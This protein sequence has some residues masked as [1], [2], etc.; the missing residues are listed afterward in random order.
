MPRLERVPRRRVAGGHILLRPAKCCTGVEHAAAW[1]GATVIPRVGEPYKH[2]VRRVARIMSGVLVLAGMVTGLVASMLVSA[3][4]M[5][6]T[7]P[8]KFPWG[9]YLQGA[10][11]AIVPLTNMAQSAAVAATKTITT[12]STGQ[13]MVLAACLLYSTLALTEGTAWILQTLDVLNA[14]VG[15]SVMG[16]LEMMLW[17]VRLVFESLVPIFNGVSLVLSD[18]LAHLVTSI[19]ECDAAD[20]QQIIIT[21]L[22]APFNGVGA[23][24]KE[25]SSWLMSGTNNAKPGETFN[26]EES[27]FTLGFNTTPAMIKWVD[28]P[29]VAIASAASCSCVQLAPALASLAGVVSQPAVHLAVMNAVNV[30]I[31]IVQ[32]LMRIGVPSV[33]HGVDAVPVSVYIRRAVFYAIVSIDG[34]IQLVL[35]G[36]FN[37]ASGAGAGRQHPIRLLNIGGPAT[38]VAHGV[39]GVG[40]LAMPAVHLLGVALGNSSMSAAEVMDV[41]PAMA[42]ASAAVHVAAANVAWLQTLVIHQV[43]PDP[44]SNPVV[45]P[46]FPVDFT[47][48]RYLQKPTACHCQMQQQSCNVGTCTFQGTCLCPAGAVHLVP[49]HVHSPCVDRCTASADCGP[50]G[51]GARCRPDGRCACDVGGLRLVYEVGGPSGIGRCTLKPPPANPS[52]NRPV[53]HVP[54]QLDFLYADETGVIDPLCGPG[55]SLVPEVGNALPC[56]VRY[57]GDAVLSVLYAVYETAR[58]GILEGKLFTGIA[59]GRPL[60]VFE[61]Y[62]G[63]PMRRS[64]KSYGTCAQRRDHPETDFTYSPTQCQCQVPHFNADNAALMESGYDPWCRVPTVEQGI[65]AVDHAMYYLGV[66]TVLEMPVESEGLE[67]LAEALVAYGQIMTE[68]TRMG[69][70]AGYIVYQQAFGAVLHAENLLLRPVN[71]QVGMPYDGRYETPAKDADA[72]RALFNDACGTLSAGEAPRQCLDADKVLQAMGGNDKDAT[73]KQ[74]ADVTRLS[75]AALYAHKYEECEKFG[76]SFLTPLC[77]VTNYGEDPLDCMCNPELEIQDGQQTLA[78]LALNRVPPATVVAHALGNETNRLRWHNVYDE[79]GSTRF[80]RAMATYEWLMYRIDSLGMALEALVDAFSMQGGDTGCNIFGQEQYLVSG[81][82][83]L[84][85]FYEIDEKSGNI[86]L[87]SLMQGLT[88]DEQS[89]QLIRDTSPN[90]KPKFSPCT[91]GEAP[92]SNVCPVVAY[93]NVLCGGGAAARTAIQGV[94]IAGRQLCSTALAVLTVNPSAID[95]EFGTIMCQAMREEAVLAGIFSSALSVMVDAAG[96][97]KAARQIRR[98]LARGTFTM[99]DAVLNIWPVLL[100]LLMSG[101]NGMVTAGEGAFDLT[102][103]YS[104]VLMIFDF[105]AAILCQWLEAWRALFAALGVDA[106]FLQGVKDVLGIAVQYINGQLLEFLIVIGRAATHFFTFVFGFNPGFSV[107]IKDLLLVVGVI[108]RFVLNNVFTIIRLFFLTLGSVGHVINNM[109]T[110]TCSAL[111]GF[112]GMIV[113]G[114]NHIPL[115]SL[116]NPFD[117]VPCVRRRLVEGNASAGQVHYGQYWDSWTAR[118]RAGPDAGL[119]LGTGPCALAMHGHEKPHDAVI[120]GCLRNRAFVGRVRRA[121]GVDDLPLDV[122]DGLRPAVFWVSG[123]L[124][125]LLGGGDWAASARKG[126][127]AQSARA[128]YE[129]AGTIAARAAT[130]LGPDAWRRHV[131]PQLWPNDNVTDPKSQRFGAK[132]YRALGAAHNLGHDIA[133]VQFSNRTEG[134]APSWWGDDLYNEGEKQTVTV[135]SSDVDV[136]GSR[137]RLAANN[138]HVAHKYDTGRRLGA[139][140]PGSAGI[141][142]SENAAVEAVLGAQQ[143]EPSDEECPSKLVCTRCRVLDS[144]LGSLVRYGKYVGDYFSHDGPYLQ[145]TSDFNKFMLSDQ[146]DFKVPRDGGNGDGVAGH[147]QALKGALLAHGDTAG[148]YTAFGRFLT[149]SSADEVVGYGLGE[150]LPARFLGLFNACDPGPKGG[151]FGCEKPK[152]SVGAA[153]F[154]AA[155]ATWLSASLG[156]GVL[157]GSL[158]AAATFLISRYT[159]VPRCGFALPPCLVQDAQLALQS[160][161]VPCLCTAVAPSLVVSGTCDPNVCGLGDFKA[162]YRDC[163]TRNVLEY[164]LRL[165]RH[166]SPATFYAL[167]APFFADVPALG[168]EDLLHGV[169]QG[170]PLDPQS[171]TCD[172]YL[173]FPVSL[174]VATLIVGPG[175]AL[176]VKLAA[177]QVPAVLGVVGLGFQTVGAA[178]KVADGVN[179]KHGAA[180]VLNAVLV[181]GYVV[182]VASGT[183]RTSAMAAIMDTSVVVVVVTHAAAWAAAWFFETKT[184]AARTTKRWWLIVATV[185]AAVVPSIGVMLVASSWYVSLATAIDLLVAGMLALSDYYVVM[186]SK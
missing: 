54:E 5:A 145:T 175:F 171:V 148:F 151:D 17:V 144:L 72:A 68:A 87:K 86:R 6:V 112:L 161:L 78:C 76:S 177:Q 110:E 178:E 130:F 41:M 159:W 62:Q 166:T 69:I 122:L 131:V 170:V 77:Q 106:S 121:L 42:H 140:G 90:A 186:Q 16:F 79:I 127:P 108:V 173:G 85:V 45:C 18:T 67:A 81:H 125:V 100:N 176:A 3:V 2:G 13:I 134:V 96:E 35:T 9:D 118:G 116:D 107:V 180:W 33:F 142:P 1:H 169:R 50:P 71:C 120:E 51:S 7:K 84:S 114:I 117:P 104:L 74:L 115:V 163:P 99:I 23:L 102:T 150:P 154:R 25:W 37:T 80:T 26:Y 109:L 185:V 123:V 70:A 179:I 43:V 15:N 147:G 10:T 30:P 53:V 149:S 52:T 34:A 174:L 172:V 57:T 82:T 31:S 128:V 47:S 111:F 83:T 124:Q 155:V 66:G 58:V 98:A 139:V 19:L 146:G 20:G 22:G 65:A 88:Y 143:Q 136:E 157:P 36:I 152:A 153:A 55:E 29:A 103:V 75:A 184:S 91:D 162:R 158:V 24:V 93:D 95:I 92:P 46:V 64:L 14:S 4:V 113:D 38:A 137:R 105:W 183:N 11:I 129:V 133:E 97:H 39:V 21:L 12:P 141:V 132:V 40:S 94:S 156:Y 60:G 49:G 138:K 32:M 164:P 61:Q 56:V 63:L 119:W 27:V 59:E 73:K 168:L 101:L 135:S 89:G 165:W 126:L 181:L 48:P 182:L 160:V 8:S 44:N 167:M 28:E